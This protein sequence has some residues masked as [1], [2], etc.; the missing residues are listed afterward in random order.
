[1]NDDFDTSFPSFS[2]EWDRNYSTNKYIYQ[3]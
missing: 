2:W 3:L 1:M